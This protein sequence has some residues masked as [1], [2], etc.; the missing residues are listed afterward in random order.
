MAWTGSAWHPLITGLARSWGTLLLTQ[1]VSGSYGPQVWAGNG[2][3]GEIQ[4]VRLDDAE[5]PTRPT[6]TTYLITYQAS[7]TW[8]SA[9]TDLG[10][11]E[12]EKVGYQVDVVAS[13]LTDTETVKVEYQINDDETAWTPLGITSQSP[14]RYKM[15]FRGGEGLPFFSIRFRLTLARGSTSTRTPKVDALVL[16]YLDSPDIRYAHNLTLSIDNEDDAEFLRA[17]STQKES[18]AFWPD[19][20]DPDEQ[21]LVRVTNGPVDPSSNVFPRNVQVTV[22]SPL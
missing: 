21:L 13:G 14:R 7:G 1:Q 20:E 18:F 22:A 11:S 3:G 2:A 12:F 15:K 4:R 9:W 16:R 10:F 5:D 8:T 17:L 6:G 19:D